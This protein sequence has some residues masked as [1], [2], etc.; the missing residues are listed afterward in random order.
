VNGPSHAVFSREEFDRRRK[1]VKD[2]QARDGRVLATASV[3]LGVALLFAID[4]A[5]PRMQR[6]PLLLLAAGS[7]LAYLAIFGVWLLRM[8]IR[9]RDARLVCPH[10]GIELDAPAEQFAD[11]EGTCDSCGERVIE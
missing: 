5:E 1:R 10:C 6:T 4:W 9:L 11:A 2:L 7:F 8:R 3:V